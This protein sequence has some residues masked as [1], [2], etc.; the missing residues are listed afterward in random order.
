MGKE[1]KNY[2]AS[3]LERVSEPNKYERSI[4]I[5]SDGHNTNWL[6]L[7]D[8]SATEIVKWLKKHYNVKD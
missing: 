1:L 2:Y 7:N 5:R 6:G 4:Q 8:E 3:Q